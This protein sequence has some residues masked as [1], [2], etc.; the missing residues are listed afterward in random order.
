MAGR[1]KSGKFIPGHKEGGR[2]AKKGSVARLF[3][4]AGVSLVEARGIAI[5]KTVEDAKAGKAWAV[6]RLWSLTM[7]EGRVTPHV[8]RGANAAD[9]AQAV[10]DALNEGALTPREAAE[11]ARGA[12]EHAAEATEWQEVRR[13]LDAA[14]A[15][16]AKLPPPSV[17]IVEVDEA[18]VSHPVIYGPPAGQ[19]RS[20]N[21][22]PER[23]SD[24]PGPSLGRSSEEDEDF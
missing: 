3:N 20:L 9:R 12:L 23:N 8:A 10:V 13:L 22:H 11:I 6:S 5:R 1:D 4:D 24:V 17:S 14:E 21:A 18:G 7:P 2:G 16:Q 19:Q 15:R